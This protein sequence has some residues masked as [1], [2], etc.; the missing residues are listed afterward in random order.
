MATAETHNTGG[1][2]KDVAVYVCLLVLAGIQFVIAYQDITT[3]QMFVRM[4]TVAIIESG[5]ALLFFMHLSKNRGLMWFVLI[6]TVA[7]ILGM[8]YGWTDSFR[9]IDGVPWAK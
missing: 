8:Q 6:F 1:I 4:L 7:V 9:L 5:I 2:G 3:S